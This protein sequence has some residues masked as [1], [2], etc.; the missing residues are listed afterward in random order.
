MLIHGDTYSFNQKIITF[1]S[2]GDEDSYKFRDAD[3]VAILLLRQNVVACLEKIR[4]ENLFYKNDKVIIKLKSKRTVI[5]D[6]NIVINLEEG[7]TMNNQILNVYFGNSGKRVYSF[8]ISK[9]GN[10]FAELICEVEEL[11]LDNG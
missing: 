2:K 11:S 7:F 1:L 6:K 8:D 10:D 9:D 4:L 5:S 3:N